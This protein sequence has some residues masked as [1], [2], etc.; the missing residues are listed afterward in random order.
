MI[1][2]INRFH[3][4]GSIKY[5]YAK[6]DI[7][8]SRFITLKT[9]VNQRSSH[10]RLAVVISKKTLKSAVRRNLMRRRIYGYLNTKLDVIPKSRDIV[11]IV[12][13][14]EIVSLT[15]S[16]LRELVDSLFNEADLYKKA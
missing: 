13:S 11:L 16:E 2:Y 4:R 1:P 8:R 5:V 10:S 9:V 3:R 12:T 14:A 7:H 15:P 6:G